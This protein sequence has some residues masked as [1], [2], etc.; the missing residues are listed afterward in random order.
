MSSVRTAV[1]PAGGF[2]TRFLPCTKSIPKEMFPLGHKPVIQ[3]VVEEVVGAGIEHIIFVVSHR[4]TSV[5]NHFSPNELLE[6]YLIGAGKGEDVERLR[7]LTR[8]ARFTFVHTLP[9]YGNAGALRAARHLLNGE[10]FALLWSDEVMLTTGS[11]RLTR[12]LELFDTEGLPV[13][14]SVAIPE[15]ERRMHYGMAELRAYKDNPHVQEI[16]RI[17]EKPR[18]GEEPSEYATHGA[19]ILPSRVFD[20][21]D[22]T[23]PRENGEYVLA[24]VLTTLSHQMTMLAQILPDAT[25]LDCGNPE[26]YLR[27]QVLYAALHGHAIQV[28]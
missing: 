6:E 23:K 3:H 5:Q 19:Y 21:L 15:P 11:S 17:V 7:E 1:I 2:G 16:V 18:A 24:D 27:S 14:S 4:K 8:L 10:P 28:S 20:A 13:I 25:Y 26:E 22:D 12:C 9:P